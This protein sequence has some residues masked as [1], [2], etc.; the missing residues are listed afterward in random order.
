MADRAVPMSENDSGRFILR[1]SQVV[2]AVLLAW[3]A[4]AMTESQKHQA[5]NGVENI[6]EVLSQIEISPDSPE[7]SRAIEFCKTCLLALRA[8]LNGWSIGQLLED[9][10]VSLPLPEIPFSELNS[11][12]S[13]GHPSRHIYHEDVQA[14]RGFLR[15]RMQEEEPW[16]WL[17]SFL[18]II[19]YNL[20]EV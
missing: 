3:Q 13:I 18:F 8:H 16:T 11:V 12:W 10:M 20:D 5:C 14:A 9:V 6:R 7:H 15:L 4:D 1:G 19:E 2:E 17:E